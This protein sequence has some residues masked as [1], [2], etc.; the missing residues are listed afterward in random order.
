[1]KEIGFGEKRTN[2]D[3]Q[4]ELDKK[5]PENRIETRKGSG[6]RMLSYA[7]GWFVI[8]EL[9]R[10]FGYDGWSFHVEDLTHKVSEK[11]GKHVA[12]SVCRGYLQINGSMD[13]FSITK[14]DV[15]HGHGRG[16]SEGEA[17]ESADKEAVTDCKKR[18][19]KD[20]GYA[21][22]LALYDKTQAMVEGGVATE[23]LAGISRA[24]TLAELEEVK[25]QALSISHSQDLSSTMATR[26]KEAYTTR[27]SQLA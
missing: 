18:C 16:G 22:G 27:K 24:K 8:S 11:D 21:V 12:Y 20:L 19:A 10:I 4:S 6:G 14:S 3:V 23:L 15:G 9:N 26:V 1:M 25:R 17:L 13:R 5:F 2:S 7:E